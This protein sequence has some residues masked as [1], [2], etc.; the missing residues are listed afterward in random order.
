M[1]VKMVC[2]TTLVLVKA[3]LLLASCL[4]VLNVVRPANA[5]GITGNTSGVIDGRLWTIYTKSGSTGTVS[6]T[7]GRNGFYSGSWMNFKGNFTMGTGWSGNNSPT[8]TSPVNAN[9]INY[10]GYNIGSYEDDKKGA[11]SVYGKVNAGN[12]FAEV[13]FYIVERWKST[14]PLPGEGTKMNRN[15]PVQ[16]GGASYDIWKVPKSGFVQ[17]WSVRTSQAPLNTNI[18]VPVSQHFA[19]WESFDMKTSK[20]RRFLFLSTESLSQLG[21]ISQGNVGATVWGWQ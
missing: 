12:G 8:Y 16:I 21:G 5:Q 15:G 11:V 17:Y 7:P 6:I 2:K 4:T 19:T 13:E 14:S 18:T 10:V 20:S 1:R 3:T 9:D